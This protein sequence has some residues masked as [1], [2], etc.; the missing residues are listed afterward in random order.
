[1]SLPAFM[2][3]FTRRWWLLA[4]AALT[5]ASAA[6]VVVAFAAAVNAAVWLLV[7]WLAVVLV[8]AGRVILSRQ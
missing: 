1:M 4:A 5:L 3:P 8:N 2:S 6:A 7:L